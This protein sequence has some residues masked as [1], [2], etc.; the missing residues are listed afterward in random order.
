MTKLAAQGILRFHPAY[1]LWPVDF[2]SLEDLPGFLDW[3][4]VVES[5]V[6]TSSGQLDLRLQFAFA[7]ELAMEPRWYYEPTTRH[8]TEAPSRAVG[9]SALGKTE[10]RFHYGNT[11]K[12]TRPSTASGSAGCM[13]SPSY[14]AMRGSLIT[15]HNNERRAYDG[16]FDRG[17][18][19]LVAMDHSAAE[20]FHPNLGYGAWTDRLVGWVWVIRPGERSL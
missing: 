1:A 5:Q 19:Q 11:G 18:D 2:L 3:V 14:D 10:I 17:I 7:G 9:A 8:D 6:R 16:T 15:I 12:P 4:Y 13:V 20:R